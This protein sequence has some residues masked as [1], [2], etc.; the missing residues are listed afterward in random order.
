MGFS[1]HF[2]SRTVSCE[3]WNVVEEGRTSAFKHY[4]Q[5][6][7]SKTK[8]IS[9]EIISNFSL[10]DLAADWRTHCMTSKLYKLCLGGTSSHKRLQR[11]TRLISHINREAIFCC[12]CLQSLCAEVAANYN[13]QY[14]GCWLESSLS[15]RWEIFSSLGE[16]KKGFSSSRE[17]ISCHSALGSCRGNNERC[18]IWTNVLPMF[19]SIIQQDP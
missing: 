6:W 2:G 3:R 5:D 7:L 13:V 16:S 12:F 14:V 18:D 10:E 4:C 8:I 15:T 9:A 17:M 1:L 11:R 19:G